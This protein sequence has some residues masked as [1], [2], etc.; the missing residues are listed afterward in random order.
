MGIG[1]WELLLIILLI[2][3]VFGHKKL[4]D[5]MGELGKGIRTFKDSMEKDDEPSTGPDTAAAAKTLP[6]GEQKK[7]QAAAS[8]E[9]GREAP[10]KGESR[11]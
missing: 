11:S 5:I 2:V 7:D 6:A 3:V 10:P 8:S 4:P 1:F 9:A